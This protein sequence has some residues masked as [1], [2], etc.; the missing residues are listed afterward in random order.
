MVF[1]KNST[2]ALPPTITITMSVVKRAWRSKRL[3]KKGKGAKEFWRQRVEHACVSGLDG[4]RVPGGRESK[5]VPRGGRP[6]GPGR[7]LA[8]RPFRFHSHLWWPR[9]L[10]EPRFYERAAKDSLDPLAL[11]VLLHR[12]QVV[13]RYPF[14]HRELDLVLR[15]LGHLNSLRWGQTL[16]GG[17]RIADLGGR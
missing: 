4:T 10:D 17:T 8:P 12:L 15:G 16:Q 9:P 11:R 5:P 7:N 2:P 6:R 13:L 14:G 1:N 3:G